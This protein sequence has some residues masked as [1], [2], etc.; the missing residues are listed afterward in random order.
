MGERDRG[1][2]VE[3]LMCPVECGVA[4]A[5]DE[6]LLAAKALGIEH[7]IVD[8]LSVP[9]L[10]AGLRKAARRERAD[11]RGDHDCPGRKAVGFG[12]QGEGPAVLLEGDDALIEMHRGAELLGLLEL[13]RHE[14][15]REHARKPRDVKD[16]LLRVEGCELSPGLRK[17]VDDLRGHTTHARIEERE[18]TG[19]AGA[20]NRDV[21]GVVLHVLTITRG[22]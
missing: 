12:D 4:T 8:S 16:V 19:R 7:A 13:P 10:R 21:L 15:L 14:V 18:E 11:A 2:T 20:E 5:D 1:G 17:R 3:Q 6:Y 22:E 9:G